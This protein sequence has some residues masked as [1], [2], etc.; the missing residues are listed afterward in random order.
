MANPYCRFQS[1]S[2]H[3]QSPTDRLAHTTYSDLVICE[4]EVLRAQRQGSL[5]QRFAYSMA[6]GDKIN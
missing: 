1:H 2:Q 4:H 5:F 3:G 6:A